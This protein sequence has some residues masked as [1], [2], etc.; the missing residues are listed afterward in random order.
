MLSLLVAASIESAHQVTL[1]LV[2]AKGKPIAN[3]EVW[4]QP[5]SSTKSVRAIGYQW[6]IPTDPGAPHGRSDARGSVTL[7]QVKPKTPFMVIAR[8]SPRFDQYVRR[9]QGYF[10]N[11]MDIIKLDGAVYAGVNTNVIIADNY[12]ISG[13]V[14]ERETGKPMSGVVIYLSD[15]LMGHMSG[16]PR[17]ELDKTKT[18]SNGRYV[19]RNLP[20]CFF[21]LTPIEFDNPPGIQWR[22][23]PHGDWQNDGYSAVPIEMRRSKVTCD[24]RIVGKGK[25]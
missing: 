16:Y 7:S 8:L 2:D 15:T 21:S 14:T 4:L 24:F 1:T 6:L 3:R 12:E 22:F 11:S 17:T 18:D 23:S 5:T 20:N 25:G 13:R 9:Q 19:F 10:R